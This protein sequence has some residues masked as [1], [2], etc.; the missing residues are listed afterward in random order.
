MSTIVQQ[1]TKFELV[2]EFLVNT[3]FKSVFFS[4]PKHTPL[5]YRRP[6]KITPQL[7]PT[8]LILL[9]KHRKWAP[10][11]DQTLDAIFPEER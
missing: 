2:L 5:K 9:P 1:F 6:I 7:R 10:T 3:S 4:T 8:Y 11:A